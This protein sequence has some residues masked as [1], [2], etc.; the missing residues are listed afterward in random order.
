VWHR[1]ADS[2]GYVERCGACLDDFTKHLIQKRRVRPAGFEGVVQPGFRR[3]VN[4]GFNG[5][6]GF[7]SAAQARKAMQA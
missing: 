6:I 2:V 3:Q 1:P 7:G 5:C 4:Q